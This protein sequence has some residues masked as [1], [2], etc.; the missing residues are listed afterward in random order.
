[1]IINYL[2]TPRFLI[3]YSILFCGFGLN[4]WFWSRFLVF[5]PLKY[6]NKIYSTTVLKGLSDIARDKL[7]VNSG[8]YAYMVVGLNIGYPIN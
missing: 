2:R 7:T 6:E 3:E 8:L 5:L 4:F 1:M